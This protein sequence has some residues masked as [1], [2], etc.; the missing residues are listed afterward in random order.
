MFKS[1]ELEFEINGDVLTVVDFDWLINKIDAVYMRHSE[2]GSKGEYAIYIQQG[3]EIVELYFRTSDEIVAVKEYS[4]LCD[5]LKEVNPMFDNSVKFPVLIN[6]ANLKQV[7]YQK[8]CLQSVVNLKFN[9]YHL[10]IYGSKKTYD[11]ILDKLNNVKEFN[12]TI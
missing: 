4:K 12:K 3:S 6:Y 2:I 8:S 10:N 7:E 11:R 5:A 1:K 9:N